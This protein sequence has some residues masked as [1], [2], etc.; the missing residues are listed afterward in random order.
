MIDIKRAYKK[1]ALKYH[2]DKNPN[3]E[4]VAKTFDR[5]KR[6][7]EILSDPQKKRVYDK[8][9]SEGVRLLE[10]MQGERESPQR[11][12]NRHPVAKC[13]F[14]TLGVLTLGYGCC[15]LC[16]CCNCCGGSCTGL[17][18]KVLGK[19]FVGLYSEAV[20]EADLREHMAEELHLEATDT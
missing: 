12:L 8:F 6:S 20:K 10:E 9:G 5:I 19:T 13:L 16:W 15:C 3:N 7:Y 17:A 4:E 14:Y 11:C 2:P 18:T 1:L